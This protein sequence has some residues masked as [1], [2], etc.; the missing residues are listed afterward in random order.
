MQ[1]CRVNQLWHNFSRS[2]MCGQDKIGHVSHTPFPL[3]YSS[4]IHWDLLRLMYVPNLKFLSSLLQ[5]HERQ[6]QLY[7]IKYEKLHMNRLAIEKQPSRTLKV[8]ALRQVMYHLLSVACS[9]LHCL[10]DIIDHFRK[11]KE[12]TWVT[13]TMPTWGM[14]SVQMPIVHM[15]NQCTKLKSLTKNHGSHKFSQKFTFFTQDGQFHW[16]CPNHEIMNYVAP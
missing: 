16:T 5:Q 4:S 15:A 1:L 3:G 6:C 11:F 13:M 8:I 2:R 12:V 7:K 9:I 14:M 10:R